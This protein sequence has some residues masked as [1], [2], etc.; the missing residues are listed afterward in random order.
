MPEYTRRAARR[1]FDRRDFIATLARQVPTS[2][3]DPVAVAGSA[4]HGADQR[5][6][7]TTDDLT[8]HVGVVLLRYQ[9][10]LVVD[11]RPPVSVTVEAHHHGIPL[12]VHSDPEGHCVLEPVQH[13]HVS[14][15]VTGG[16]PRTRTAWV[17]L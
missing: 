7:F 15:L 14:L 5:L 2:E 13:G 17:L 12:V 11:V 9:L 4:G 16:A 10:R 6:Q 3:A 8:V 1:T